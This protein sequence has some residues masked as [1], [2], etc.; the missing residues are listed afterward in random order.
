MSDN[1]SSGLSEP[2]DV[3]DEHS[4]EAELEAPDASVRDNDTEASTERFEETP[5]KT[6]RNIRQDQITASN[7][8]RLRLQE[9]QGKDAG[10]HQGDDMTQDDDGHSDQPNSSLDVGETAPI[11][12]KTFITRWSP[13]ASDNISGGSK[14]KRSSS[15]TSTSENELHSADMT[16]D[17]SASLHDHGEADDTREAKRGSRLKSP[18]DSPTYAVEDTNVIAGWRASDR[19]TPAAD[20]NVSI[21]PSI[22]RVKG[23]R[24]SDEESAITERASLAGSEDLEQPEEEEEDD[25]VDDEEDAEGV[26]KLDVNEAQ[27]L[28]AEE[29]EAEHEA[30]ASKNEDER[31]LLPRCAPR[32][33]ASANQITDARKKAALEKL[34]PIENLFAIFRDR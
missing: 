13:I 17:Q 26:A 16:K 6:H 2:A 3:L 11:S 19:D 31:E 10:G 25:E 34:M 33:P 30:E 14:R 8:S 7:V 22:R 18:R 1:G 29:D 15:L 27:A 23:R 9:I 32:C 28:D 4:L 24:D 21:F 20:E 5:Q 12:N